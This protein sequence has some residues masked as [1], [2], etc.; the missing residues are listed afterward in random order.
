MHDRLL[1]SALGGGRTFGR[2]GL[3]A[4]GPRSHP[5]GD[6][7]GAADQAAARHPSRQTLAFVD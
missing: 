6:T 3:Q 1:D 4:G 7:R 5:G 2:G